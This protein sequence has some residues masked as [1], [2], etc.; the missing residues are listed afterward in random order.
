MLYLTDP[1]HPA[2]LREEPHLSLSE[3]RREKLAA[4]L[5]GQE[6]MQQR[7]RRAVAELNRLAA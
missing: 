6:M 3:T 7:M 5:A 1:L 2:V 4:V